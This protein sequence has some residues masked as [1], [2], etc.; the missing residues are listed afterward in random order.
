MDLTNNLE[1]QAVYVLLVALICFL[2]KSNFHVKKSYSMI[3][4]KDWGF[5]G[6]ECSVYV[7]LG[8]CFLLFISFYPWTKNSECPSLTF[9]ILITSMDFNYI[10]SNNSLFFCNFR[11]T[12]GMCFF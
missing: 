11:L 9:I 6:F 4:H 7:Y 1:N 10:S 8:S 5:I 3:K 12:L 2:T